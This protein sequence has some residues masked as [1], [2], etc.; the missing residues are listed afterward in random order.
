[1]VAQNTSGKRFV[2]SKHAKKTKRREKTECGVWFR[3]VLC[4]YV[5]EK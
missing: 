5:L 2:N 4:V 3:G 1:M